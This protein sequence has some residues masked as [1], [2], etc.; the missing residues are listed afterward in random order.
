MRSASFLPLLGLAFGAILG[1]LAGLPADQPSAPVPD[2][3]PARWEKDL[4]AF[5][6]ADR[7][8]PPAKGGILFLGSSSIRKWDTLAQDFRGWPVLNR[9]FGGSHMSDVVA[10][11]DRLVFP[12]EPRQIILYEG[13]N[14][15]GAGKSAV[16]ILED[17][18]AFV[19][20]VHA[21]LPECRISLLAIKP[22]PK[23]QPVAATLRETNTALR[24]FT[25]SSPR[26]DFIDIHTP[27]LGADGQ[28]RPELFVEDDL[29]LNAAGY[30][31]WTRIIRPYLH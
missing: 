3:D 10:L 5:A 21:R 18:Q 7:A 20:V 12:C 26:L 25:E 17:F 13:D 19:R 1:P 11:A 22:S 4:E 27:M 24:A 30:A 9:G 2:P 31:L 15:V 29:H 16:Q 6:Q 28:P 23:R 8:N 14:D